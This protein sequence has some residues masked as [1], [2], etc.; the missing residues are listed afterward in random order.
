[1]VA[2]DN[3]LE[4]LQ[5]T[6]RLLFPDQEVNSLFFASCTYRDD[7]V[8]NNAYVSQAAASTESEGLYYSRPSQTAEEIEEQV[9]AGGFLGLKSYL[10]MA[11]SYLPGDEI[12]VFD[13]FPPHQL[14]VCQQ[15]GW[16]VMLHIPRSKRFRDP[17]NLAR[18]REIKKSYPNVKLIVAHMGR[19]YCQED[20]GNARRLIQEVKERNK[21]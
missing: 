6:Y 20:V 19:A 4:D 10:D 13:F 11:P 15:H 14:E 21:K 2:K 18:I 17:V 9:L 7:I 3:P 1:M 16:I 12:R 5:E 8:A